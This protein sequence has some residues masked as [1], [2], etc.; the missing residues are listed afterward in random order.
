MYLRSLV[1]GKTPI[2]KSS[3]TTGR[4]QVLCRHAQYTL[5]VYNYFRSAVLEV[6]RPGILK[7]L[8]L[9][10]ESECLQGLN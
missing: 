7:S 4:Q 5:H 9:Q 1:D 10:T 2:M 8:V 6:R 3:T